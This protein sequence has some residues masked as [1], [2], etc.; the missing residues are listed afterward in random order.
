MGLFFYFI[1]EIRCVF[2]AFHLGDL[3]AEEEERD[4]VH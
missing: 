2:E 4:S 1:W 3:R